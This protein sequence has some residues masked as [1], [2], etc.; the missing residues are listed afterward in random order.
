MSNKSKPNIQDLQHEDLAA[1]RGVDV[2]EISVPADLKENV[3]ELAKYE[4][5]F[6]NLIFG[7]G[8][9]RLFA[10]TGSLKVLEDVGILSNIKRL[11]GTSLGA[12]TACFIALGLTP[13]Q[14]V[15]EVE[16]ARCK[17]EKMLL[18]ARWGILSLIFNLKSEYGW[19][20]ANAYTKWLEDNIKDYGGHGQLTFK[21]LYEN[22]GKELCCVATNLNLMTAEYCH[23]KTTPDLPI[24]VALRMS[25]S[26]P[27][28][29]C[30]VKHN[31]R[32]E[33]DIYVDGGLLCNYPIHVYD[34]WWLSM[35]E[36]NT[37]FKKLR[38]AANI[39]KLYDTKERFKE[40]NKETLG[41]CLYT[42]TESSLMQINFN[43]RYCGK[44]AKIPDTKLARKRKDTIEKKKKCSN[45]RKALASSFVKFFDV[46][47]KFDKDNSGTLSL[48]EFND[49]FERSNTDDFTQEDFRTL[50]GKDDIKIVF[51]EIDKNNSGEI[52][53]R[54]ILNYVDTKG[55]HMLAEFVG[56]Q[57]Q[58]ITGFGSYLMALQNSVFNH[59]MREYVEA[60][61]VER[62]VG[63]DTY[64]INGTDFA[65][66]IEDRNFLYEQ[67]FRATVAYL[68]EFV[69]SETLKPKKMSNK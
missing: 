34:G 25:M 31:L 13:H 66:D 15:V 12:L 52:T 58:T 21:E 22:T 4:Y 7:G 48:A 9:N 26:L 27:A 63:I 62:T 51:K 43:E 53:T 5:P 37:F 19:H 65:I 10:Y 60:T 57:R 3:K 30:A 41:L 40:K 18:D 1:L 20:P 49:L 59:S 8:G 28:L 2:S 17:V 46:I 68:E 42:E 67:G 54:E 29:L 64:Y 44:H 38:P 56:Y 32:G 69:K 33:D 11:G 47:D 39:A 24:I 45:N 36:E 50:F 61:D 23:V 55:L 14:L 6:R 16:K 35:K